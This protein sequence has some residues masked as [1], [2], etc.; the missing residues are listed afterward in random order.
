MGAWIAHVE[1]EEKGDDVSRIVDL[2]S[3]GEKKTF[4]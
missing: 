3:M 2:M 1:D 4:G